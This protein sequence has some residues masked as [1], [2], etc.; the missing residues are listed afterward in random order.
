MYFYKIA[1]NNFEL[2]SDV[3]STPHQAIHFG[4][5]TTLISR[6]LALISNCKCIAERSVGRTLLKK[7]EDREVAGGKSIAAYPI[8]NHLTVILGI[9]KTPFTTDLKFAG[10]LSQAHT[11][12]SV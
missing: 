2:I 3:Q 11:R 12:D 8:A 4:V 7:Y 1:I 9:L 5:C 6:A 10:F